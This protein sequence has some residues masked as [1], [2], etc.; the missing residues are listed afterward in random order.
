[1]LRY[2]AILRLL[3]DG[4]LPAGPPVFLAPVIAFLVVALGTLI[5]QTSIG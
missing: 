3:I 2:Q 5:I 4:L 1:M